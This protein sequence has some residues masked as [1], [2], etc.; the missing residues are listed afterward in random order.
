MLRRFIQRR[1]QRLDR[2]LG[3]LR[4][5]YGDDGLRLAGDRVVLGAAAE[6]DEPQLRLLQSV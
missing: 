5:G 3:R 2:G 4:I 6:L 1:V